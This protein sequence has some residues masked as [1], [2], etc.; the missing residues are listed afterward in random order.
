MIVAG[1]GEADQRRALE[2]I[3]TA[4]A[5]RGSLVLAADTAP[6]ERV[7]AQPG[8]TLFTSGTTGTP[9]AVHRPWDELAAEVSS[10]GGREDR[11]LLTYNVARYAGLQVALHCLVHGAELLV[12]ARVDDVDAVIAA[13]AA[14]THM[15]ATPSLVRRIA[16]AHGAE[17]MR[18][19]EQITLGGEYATQAVLDLAARCWPGARVTS[20]YASSEA[21]TCFAASDGLEGFPA[22][23]LGHGRAGRVGRLEDDGELVIALAAG[24]EVR[25]GDFWALQ[26]G[27]LIYRGR[28]EDLINVGGYKVSPAKVE[29]VLLGV[30][31][32]D[33]CRVIGRA[34]PVTGEVVVAELVGE[35]DVAAVRAACRA[36]LERAEV[37]GLFRKVEAVPLTAAGKAS[38]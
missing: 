25:T 36:A 11:F 8:V 6:A 35:F 3:A 16:M 29:R 19:L 13:G 37:P 14:A 7:L 32:V 33:D 12:P 28:D 4:L 38:R 21:G 18:A 1:P 24:R 2:A 27:R 22:E 30:D 17:R 31:G 20:I 10:A 26:D 15:S 34:S 9:K 5:A 23:A